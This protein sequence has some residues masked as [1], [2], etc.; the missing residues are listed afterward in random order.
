MTHDSFPIALTQ[1]DLRAVGRWALGCVERALP[2]FEASAPS[3]SRPREAVEGL[4]TFVNG[5]PRTAELRA[6]GW[7]AW[8][9][10]EVGDPAAAAAARAASL[11]AA[12]AYTHPL[13]TAH[14]ANHTLGPAGYAALAI[15]LAAGGDG[16]VGDAEIRW[17]LG[18]A[19]PR[20][21]E[22]VARMARPSIGRGRLGA[23]LRQ[24]DAGLRADPASR[25]TST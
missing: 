4:T 22:V 8:A 24:L 2:V 1:D 17:A 25:K 18:H 6:L 19:S 14:Q 10:R 11:A 21:R 5:G 7:A 16:N 23:L 20:A 3:D 9:A 13:A 12:I 15:E